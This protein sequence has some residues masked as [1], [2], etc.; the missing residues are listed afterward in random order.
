MCKETLGGLPCHCLILWDLLLSL[1]VTRKTG[2]TLAV[3]G[4]VAA[5][6][7]EK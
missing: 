7:A 6:E 3:L 5:A 4:S 2:E 1:R